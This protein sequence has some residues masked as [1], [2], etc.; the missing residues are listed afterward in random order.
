MEYMRTTIFLET[1]MKEKLRLLAFEKRCSFVSLI[2]EALDRYLEEEKIN[3][4][5]TLQK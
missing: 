1:D 2:R 4:E 3:S 5:F